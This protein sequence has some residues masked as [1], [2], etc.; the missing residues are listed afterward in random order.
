MKAKNMRMAI[1]AITLSAGCRS[2]FF[3]PSFLRGRL[4]VRHA[5]WGAV[6]DLAAMV[7]EA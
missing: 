7:E 4:C 6:P 3:A 2:D 5:G 1:E